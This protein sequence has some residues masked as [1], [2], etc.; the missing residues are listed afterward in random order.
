MQNMIPPEIKN[1]TQL[2]IL[3]KLILSQ[4]SYLSAKKGYC[5][6]GNEYFVNFFGV[7]TGSIKRSLQKMEKL[8]LITRSLAWNKRCMQLTF[9]VD[10][11]TIV[12]PDRRPKRT[13]I[14]D[15]NDLDKD[16]GKIKEKSF[17]KASDILWNQESILAAEGV[18]KR[19]KAKIDLKEEDDGT[20]YTAGFAQ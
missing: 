20:A 2:K 18:F 14:P 19:I 13:W 16:K 8:G 17:H 4:I 3:D 5:F 11:N 12:V 10:K 9:A 1:I 6:A 7:S 15:Q